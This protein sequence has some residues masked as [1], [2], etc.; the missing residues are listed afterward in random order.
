VSGRFAGL[1]VATM[2]LALA[3]GS[4][5]AAAVIQLTPTQTLVSEAT[6]DLAS[7]SSYHLVISYTQDFVAFKADLHIRP[8][9]DAV[10]WV[11]VNNSSPLQVIQTGGTLYIQGQDFVAEYGGSYEAKLFGDRWIAFTPGIVRTTVLDMVNLTALPAAFLKLQ[12]GTRVDHVAAAT[13]STAELEGAWGAMYIGELPPHALVK[14]ESA[15]GFVPVQGFSNVSLEL[16]GYNDTVDIKAPADFA[17]LHNPS[18][19]PPYFELAGGWKWGRCDWQACGFTATVTNRGGTY[20]S[21]PS[22]FTFTIRLNVSFRYIDKCAG[23]VPLVTAGKTV[24]IGCLVTSD[25]WYR[26]A[27]RGVTI[28]G[29]LVIQNPSYSG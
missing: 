12:P 16:L 28:V 27:T 13:E 7:A 14:V 17:D 15:N 22:T 4:S 20:P 24:K 21:A 1:V 25:A 6:K 26:I 29:D 2:T 5:P 3:C 19:L 9:S 23:K 11:S 18:T 10:G 8:P